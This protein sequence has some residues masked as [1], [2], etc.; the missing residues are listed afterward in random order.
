M[1]EAVFRWQAESKKRMAFWEYGGDPAEPHLV[2]PNGDHVDMC[3]DWQ[4]VAEDPVLL[5]N[6]A[7]ALV[8]HLQ[9]LGLEVHKVNRVLGVGR[10]SAA[11]AST[12]AYGIFYNRPDDHKG[13]GCYSTYLREPLA[14]DRRKSA[15][16][17][18]TIKPGE[19]VLVL[20]D[21]FM[22]ANARAALEMVGDLWANPQPII[23]AVFNLS[24]L[25]QIGQYKVGSLVAK[26]L[27]RWSSKEA[28]L[29]CRAGSEAIQPKSK[30]DWQRLMKN[31]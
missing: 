24:G 21:Y 11:L 16:R 25:A 13:E 4:K 6:G 3:F 31:D 20:L 9:S 2:A 12:A 18:S 26:Q 10:D 30:E 1:C 19:N 8:S 22:P 7:V 5:R 14:L 29:L 17:T 15:V 27:S 28:C 23:G